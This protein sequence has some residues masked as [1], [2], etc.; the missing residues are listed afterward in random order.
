MFS[1]YHLFNICIFVYYKIFSSYNRVI[2][3]QVF[4]LSFFH[5]IEVIGQSTFHLEFSNTQVIREFRR[6]WSIRASHLLF[7]LFLTRN[8]NTIRISLISN[9]WYPVIFLYKFLVVRGFAG[10]CMSLSARILVTIFRCE[11]FSFWKKGKEQ[12]G[13]Q[14]K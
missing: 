4:S 5:L 3:I 2:L 11:K 6:E 8:S 14:S 12:S 10:N 13:K 7:V 1:I 9:G